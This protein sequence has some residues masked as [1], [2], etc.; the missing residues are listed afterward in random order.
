M[1]LKLG[2]SDVPGIVL[3]H[4]QGREHQAGDGALEDVA[5]NTHLLEHL[6]RARLDEAR[7]Q[8]AH[9]ALIRS[10]R[11]VRQ[12]LRVVAGLA[13]IRAGRWLARTAPKRATVQG[14]VTA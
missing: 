1:S 9:W 4:R 5:M 11:P 6:V 8:A 10:L 12:P 13:L 14:R 3:G 2:H 7:A